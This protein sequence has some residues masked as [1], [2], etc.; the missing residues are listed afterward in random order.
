MSN[1]AKK[2]AILGASRGLGRA[3]KVE[4]SQIMGSSAQFFL[5]ARSLANLATIR[6]SDDIVFAADFTR[7][8]DQEKLLGALVEFQP[9]LIFS[10]AGGGPFGRYEQ[11]KFKDHQWAFELNFLWPARLLHETLKDPAKFKELN[12]I[13]FVGSAIAG[14]KPD[15]MAS[16]YAAAKHALRGLITSVQAEKPRLSVQIYEPGY[17]D[18][19]LLPAGAWPRQHG[20]AKSAQDEARALWQW[21]KTQLDSAPL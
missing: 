2:I 7:A 9:E 5:A 14:Q 16:S 17:I 10:V 18:T 20:L 8:D 19:D 11:K 21:A 1:K 15:P 3:L 12:Q 6:G 13:L 4:L